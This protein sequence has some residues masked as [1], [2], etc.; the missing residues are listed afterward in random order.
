HNPERILR[1]SD[2]PEKIKELV[3]AGKL[4][5]GHARCLVGIDNA[6]ELADKIISKDLSV[7]ET[8]E[9]VANQKKQKTK[10]NKEESTANSAD[11]QQIEESL[12]KALGLRI[13]ISQ[14][15]QGG[16]KVVLQ[17][18]SVAELDMIID[19]LEQKK[20]KSLNVSEQTTEIP[21]ENNEKFSIKFVD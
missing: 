19:I 7:R 5:A 3:S 14:S 11:L 4:S 13:K 20:A 17:Y 2:L 8:E 16:G 1:R 10:T 12:K 21:Q 15:K 9:L 6:E 18:A